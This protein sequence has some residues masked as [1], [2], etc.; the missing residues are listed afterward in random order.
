MGRRRLRGRWV[1]LLQTALAAALSWLVATR[2]FG[3]SP[4]PLY[5]PVAAVVAIGAGRSRRFARTAHMLGGMLVAIAATQLV[6]QAV[7][8]GVWQMATV[9]VVTTAIATVLFDEDLAVSYAAFNAAVLVALH[10]EGWVPDRLLEAAVGAGVAVAVIYV[11][12]DNPNRWV[13][14]ESQR[15]LTDGANVLRCAAEALEE[16]DSDAAD[17]LVSQTV[18]LE[19]TLASADGTIAFAV[20]TA[21]FSPWLRHGSVSETIDTFRATRPALRTVTT[22][23]RLVDRLLSQEGGPSDRAGIARDLREAARMVERRGQKVLH[24]DGDDLAPWSPEASAPDSG[25]DAG[26]RPLVAAVRHELDALARDLRVAGEGVPGQDGSPW[27]PGVGD[28]V[29]R[30][31]RKMAD[32]VSDLRGR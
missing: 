15:S 2:L 26:G 6:V 5:S 30:A 24:G 27:G 11:V 25:D 18:E 8:G 16:P 20:E 10:G 23:G 13:G 17:D 1:S 7:G 19:Q 9:V 28:G 12:P 29:G 14:H 22:I 4:A 21:R 3:E 32:T 31:G